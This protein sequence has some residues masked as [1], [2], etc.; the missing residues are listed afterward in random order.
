MAEE[1]DWEELTDYFNGFIEEDGHLEVR[2][3]SPAY[4][5]AIEVV[6]PERLKEDFMKR[7]P[8]FKAKISKGQNTHSQKSTESNYEQTQIQAYHIRMGDKIDI[9]GSKCLVIGIGEDGDSVTITAVGNDHQEYQLQTNSDT[10][11]MIYRRT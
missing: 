7:L 4:D 10:S 8:L 6:I 2:A 1:I 9:A 11:I 5:E 3:Y